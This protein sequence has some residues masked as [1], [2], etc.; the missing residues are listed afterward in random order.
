GRTFCAACSFIHHCDYIQIQAQGKWEL[1]NSYVNADLTGPLSHP[2]GSAAGPPLR[3]GACW[4][5][6]LPPTGPLHKLSR[7]KDK[8]AFRVAFPPQ[9]WCSCVLRRRRRACPLPSHCVLRTSR[10]NNPEGDLY[11]V[12]ECCQGGCCRCSRDRSCRLPGPQA[13]AV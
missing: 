11:E 6:P 12:R 13:D 8:V 3:A 10:I 7:V 2:Q 1:R 9:I 5:A 4:T